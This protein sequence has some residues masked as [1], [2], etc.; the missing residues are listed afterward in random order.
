MEEEN[1]WTNLFFSGNPPEFV[2]TKEVNGEKE[3]RPFRPEVENWILGDLADKSRPT[4]EKK[5]YRCS[6]F[7]AMV[8]E[9]T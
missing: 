5:T 7:G 4:N 3:F 1:S 6:G 8:E 2:K 9:N